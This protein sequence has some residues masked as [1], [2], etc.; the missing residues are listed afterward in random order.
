MLK[1]GDMVFH[2]KLKTKFIVI[3]AVPHRFVKCV[4]AGDVQD[5]Q[6]YE[7]EYGDVKLEEVY[8]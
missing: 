7:F 3:E 8:E 5:K 4:L 6:I 2:R 1:F